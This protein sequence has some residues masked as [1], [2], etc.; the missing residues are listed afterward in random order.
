ME[1]AEKD[2]KRGEGEEDGIRASLPIMFT[3]T[4]KSS[5]LP[6]EQLQ[7]ENMLPPSIPQST[8]IKKVATPFGF[9]QQDCNNDNT[10]EDQSSTLP[11]ASPLTTRSYNGSSTNAMSMTLSA[12]SPERQRRPL[13]LALPSDMQMNISEILNFLHVGGDEITRNLA[14]LQK[15][16]IKG[17]VNTTKD[18]D[19]LAS[20]EGG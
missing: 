11:A 20:Q 17:I 13:V 2:I 8:K 16:N 19:S 15:L 4:N 18:G 14:L 9:D 10:W 12:S 3:S 5:P 7:Q 1:E 6:L